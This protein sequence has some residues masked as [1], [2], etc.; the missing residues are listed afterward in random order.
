[1]ESIFSTIR[2]RP[3]A[4]LIL[5]L[6]LGLLMVARPSRRDPD[7]LRRPTNVTI[8]MRHVR[9][10]DHA[11]QSPGLQT[12]SDSHHAVVTVPIEEIEVGM[13]V[14]A[15]NPL[16]TDVDRKQFRDPNPD[17]WRKLHMEYRKPSGEVI[18]IAMI[19]PME[20]LQ[21]NDVYEGGRVRLEMSELGVDGL[22]DVKMI[23]PCPSIRPGPGEVVLAT[24]AQASAA[25]IVE[26][27]FANDDC[28]ETIRVTTSHPFWSVKDNSFVPI[29]RL[30]AG[31]QVLTRGDQVKTIT[32][33]LPRPGPV[34]T[35][36]NLEINNEHVYYVGRLCIL[37]HN[38]G[39]REFIRLSSGSRLDLTGPSV[40]FGK[41]AHS[42]SDGYVYVLRDRITGEPL[43]VGKTTGGVN[44][45]ERMNKYRRKSQQWGFQIEAEYW[46][47]GNSREALD[48][49]TEIRRAFERFGFSIKWDKMAA[50]NRGLPWR[51]L[52]WE[53]STDV[54]YEL[55]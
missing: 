20:W 53:R 49:E 2:E 44:I 55:E 18:L 8:E 19:R 26:V 29:G 33:I 28:N 41:T 38:N 22:A 23:G 47:V 50:H 21:A 7:S 42:S 1:M 51:G 39:C 4:T 36:Y 15:R 40:G 32:S 24:F 3:F 30:S 35:V 31:A 6:S 17:T 5:I 16:V 54:P 13:R 27:T 11:W 14:P 45:Y 46:K 9:D 25:E 12:A 43:K 48:L 34:E 37:V 52:P 10:A